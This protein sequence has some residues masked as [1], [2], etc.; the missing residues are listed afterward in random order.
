[1]DPT[2]V[3][4]VSPSYDLTFSSGSSGEHCS[5]VMGKGKKT[6]IRQLLE[7]AKSNLMRVKLLTR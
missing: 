1:M 5:M 4:R 2:G 7:V 3:W 6:G